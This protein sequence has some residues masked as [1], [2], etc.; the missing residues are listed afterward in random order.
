[1][2]L[3]DNLSFQSEGEGGKKV[4]VMW[5]SF[6]YMTSYVF[7]LSMVREH[8][9][10]TLWLMASPWNDQDRSHDYVTVCSPVRR[11]FFGLTCIHICTRYI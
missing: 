11:L 6:S 5:I 2:S 3:A 9:V 10:F 4:Y 7:S 8:K 1:M